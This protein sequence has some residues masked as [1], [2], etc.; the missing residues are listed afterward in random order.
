MA[1]I[2]NIADDYS[3]E[4]GDECE[5]MCTVVLKINGVVKVKF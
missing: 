5:T 2:N 3:D 4:T 1:N